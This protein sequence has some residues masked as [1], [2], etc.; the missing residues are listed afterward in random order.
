MPEHPADSALE[1]AIRRFVEANAGTRL[2]FRIAC[3]RIVGATDGDY[4][5]ARI[6]SPE[7]DSV[8]VVMKA[9]PDQV[10]Q[11][12][13]LGSSFD[14]GAFPS[15]VTSTAEGLWVAQG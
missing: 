12:A 15:E 4:A 8:L 14:P 5:V 1:D 13:F 2:L 10:W 11:G 3:V 6:D 9:D 7:T